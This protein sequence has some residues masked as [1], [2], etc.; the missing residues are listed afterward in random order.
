[1]LELRK[2]AIGITVIIALSLLSACGKSQQAEPSQPAGSEPAQPLQPPTAFTLQPPA[3]WQG[4]VSQNT[5]EGK[6]AAAMVPYASK[7]IEYLYQP[8]D[9]DLV[10]Q[11]LMI[12]VV[13][14]QAHW[15]LTQHMPGPALGTVLGQRN[16]Y[17]YILSLAQVSPYD[18]GGE[19]A[20]M[21]AD[22]MV[23]EAQIAEAFKLP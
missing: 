20:R 18:E 6:A 5:L 21:F 15:Q 10:A 8:Q 3:S 12:V 4:K 23:K 2:A 11:P 1:M 19:D 9:A 14:T 16:G 22:L 7:I 13:M 17:V